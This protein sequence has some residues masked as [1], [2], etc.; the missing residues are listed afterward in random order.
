LTGSIEG[1]ETLA[2]VRDGSLPLK[3]LTG[4]GKICAGALESFAS[5]RRLQESRFTVIPAELVD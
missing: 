5:N 3:E 4:F 1:H 2:F